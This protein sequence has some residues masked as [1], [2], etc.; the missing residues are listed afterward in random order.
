MN[1]FKK[2]AKAIFHRSTFLCNPLEGQCT[3]LPGMQGGRLE[4]DASFMETTQ[5]VTEELLCALLR[6]I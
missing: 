3:E 4:H 5:T 2:S 6:N 1:G